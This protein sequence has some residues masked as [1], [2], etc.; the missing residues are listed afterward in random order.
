MATTTKVTDNQRNSSQN[1]S[2]NGVISKT[3][4]E[5][6]SIQNSKSFK[7]IGIVKDIPQKTV[8]VKQTQLPYSPTS[9][10]NINRSPI[11]TTSKGPTLKLPGPAGDINSV[12]KSSEITMLSHKKKQKVNA[13]TKTV[14]GSEDDD[15]TGEPWKLIWEEAR[16]KGQV[17]TIKEILRENYK[18]VPLVAAVI[19]SIT[20]TDWDGHVVLKD[21][22]GVMEGT[23]HKKLLEGGDIVQGAAVL[24]SK[25]SVFSPSQHSHYL[26]ITPSNLD[27]VI[28]PQQ[29]E[30]NSSKKDQQP[31]EFQ[32]PA[33]VNE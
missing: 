14:N 7:G 12:T 8:T 4:K 9:T 29:K 16:T 25:V 19:K 32:N 3:G 5:N 31:S 27:K 22:T 20:I 10:K 6:N 15:F 24:L 33:V 2:N 11:P 1:N 17:Y 18:K 26:N 13:L 23:F 28:P 30:K 21:P